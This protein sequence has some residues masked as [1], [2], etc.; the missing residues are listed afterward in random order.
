VIACAGGGADAAVVELAGNLGGL[1][2]G[3]ALMLRG[4]VLAMWAPEARIELFEGR[5][6]IAHLDRSP[7]LD[8]RLDL[9]APVVLVVA[10]FVTFAL[11]V[12]G[13]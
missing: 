12:A 1:G 13:Y 9:V 4:M 5:R 3:V 6:V 11:L 8:A 7:K 2:F 10:A